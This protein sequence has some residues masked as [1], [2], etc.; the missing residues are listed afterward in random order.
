M[1]RNA[2]VGF[3]LAL[4]AIVT[5]TG[6]KSFNSKKVRRQHAESYPQA[7]AQMTEGALA[8]TGPLGL[9][10]CIRLALQH[11]LTILA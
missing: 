3:S 7:L 9:E 5:L 11:S 4:L 10:D 2:T 8:E 6:C 1:T